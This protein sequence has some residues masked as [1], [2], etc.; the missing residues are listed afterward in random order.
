MRSFAIVMPNRLAL[1][2]YAMRSLLAGIVLGSV[3]YGLDSDAYQVKMNL[4]A[5]T[6]IFVNLA[7]VDLFDGLHKR[8]D[9]YKRE[10]E[11][12]SATPLSYWLSDPTAS[13]WLNALCC[14]MC[15]LPVYYIAD[16]RTG[17]EY[18]GYFYLLLLSTVY[19]NTGFAFL[20]STFTSC[21]ITSRLVFNGI[22]M[23]LQIVF[24]GFLILLPSMASWFS[25]LAYICPMSYFLAGMLS[26]EYEG[27]DEA[28]AEGVTFDSLEDIYGFS[29]PKYSALIVTISVGLI[30]KLLW[31]LSL[32]SEEAASDIRTLRKVEGRSRITTR[33]ILSAGLRWR[34]VHSKSR[35][36]V[37]GP[38]MYS[39]AFMESND[40]Y[41]SGLEADMFDTDQQSLPTQRGASWSGA[42]RNFL[43]RSTS[44]S[45][46]NPAAGY[47]K[48]SMPGLGSGDMSSRGGASRH[49]ISAD[50]TGV[51]ELFEDDSSAYHEL[52]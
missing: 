51:F 41:I 26:N 3:W 34:G 7:L 48:R 38:A 22:L 47:A 13:F 11:T 45:D 25:W 15:S 52:M 42:I 2:F 19:C 1:L 44:Q 6:Y 46:A 39:N 50:G 20:L 29:I 4:F 14:L 32:Y 16:L 49:G 43:F 9:M 18:F 23:P 28:L 35:S 36:S 33:R 17:S 12:S 21:A 37:F 27:N 5:C 40:D 8:F 30:Y 31:L 24:S 10:R